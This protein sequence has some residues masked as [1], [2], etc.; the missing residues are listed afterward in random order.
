MQPKSHVTSI[1]NTLLTDIADR[2]LSKRSSF[3]N[4]SSPSGCLRDAVR[5]GWAFG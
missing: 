3:H 4:T 5:L 1:G 2:E